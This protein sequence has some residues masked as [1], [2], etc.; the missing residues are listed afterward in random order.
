MPLTF[1]TSEAN[2]NRTHSTPITASPLPHL[3]D[4]CYE[5]GLSSC[6]GVGV[7]SAKRDLETKCFVLFPNRTKRKNEHGIARARSQVSG[8]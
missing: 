8:V 3:A 2:S 7:R 6:V 1:T 4:R 5:L